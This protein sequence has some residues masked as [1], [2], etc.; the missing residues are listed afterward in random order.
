ML[1]ALNVGRQDEAIEEDAINLV[2]GVGFSGLLSLQRGEARGFAFYGGAFIGLSLREA[3][4]GFTFR[5]FD[6]EGGAFGFL[7]PLTGFTGR[8]VA[9]LAKSG[10]LGLCLPL[11]GFGGESG[12]FRLG[13]FRAELGERGGGGFGFA[14]GLFGGE[15]VGFGFRFGLFTRL[16]LPLFHLRFLGGDAFGLICPVELRAVT[17]IAQ[18]GGQQDEQDDHNDKDILFHGGVGW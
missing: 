16:G 6:G 18:S 14:A 13:L 8:G 15:A 17:S 5:D 7:R 2:G 9:L 3:S 12:L 1:T 11:F 10:D 4:R